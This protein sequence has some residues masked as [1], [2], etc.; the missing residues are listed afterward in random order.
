MPL[1]PRVAGAYALTGAQPALE[2]RD[3]SAAAASG[4]MVC[5]SPSSAG[6]GEARAGC[7]RQLCLL[8]KRPESV[9]V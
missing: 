8:V 2:E 5:K 7:G 9:G 4:L 1:R 3:M 6:G